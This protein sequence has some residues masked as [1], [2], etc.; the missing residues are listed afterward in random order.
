M[1]SK[2]ALERDKKTLFQIGG[3]QEEQRTGIDRVR[4]NQD[5]KNR[6]LTT[7]RNGNEPQGNEKVTRCRGRRG[8]ETSKAL[9]QP[10]PFGE[11]PGTVGEESV[12]KR[13][14]RKGEGRKSINELTKT[15]GLA[16]K[17]ISMTYNKK[18]STIER[19]ASECAR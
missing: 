1:R 4:R 2:K 12:T 19:R 6:S 11:V 5:G 16:E 18:V 13:V 17:E 14:W 9:N 3:V 8:T 15:A 7:E 10:N